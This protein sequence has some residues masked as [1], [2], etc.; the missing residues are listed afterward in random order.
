[1][2]N[3]IFQFD[4]FLTIGLNLLF[5]L[6]LPLYYL[7]AFRYKDL[8]KLLSQAKLKTAQV[9]IISKLSIRFGKLFTSKDLETT[10]LDK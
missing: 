4:F 3:N 5:S 9:K 6:G 1:M 8:C 7:I 10:K 2:R